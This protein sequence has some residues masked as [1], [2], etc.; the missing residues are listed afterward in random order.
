MIQ[1]NRFWMDFNNL[2]P[3]IKEFWEEEFLDFLSL[4]P[5][6]TEILFTEKDNISDW[7]NLKEILNDYSWEK[8]NIV[9]EKFLEDTY[10]DLQYTIE[11]IASEI[12]YY[13]FHKL[14]FIYNENKWLN[15]LNQEIL[16]NEEDIFWW[17]WYSAFLSILRLEVSFEL[18][19]EI[20][21]KRDK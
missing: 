14:L 3:A 1:V 6:L 16:D 8:V 21:D 19:D 13:E 18:R 10:S 5:D 9:L 2:Q 4:Y 12:T 17:D 20:A 7:N 15:N 11:D